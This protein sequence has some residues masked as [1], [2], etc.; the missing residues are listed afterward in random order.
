M[1]INYEKSSSTKA[2]LILDNEEEHPEKINYFVRSENKNRIF[3]KRKCK[4]CENIFYTR[5]N[6]KSVYCS[7][8]CMKED[9]TIEIICP[10][11]E[12]KVRVEKSKHESTKNGINFCSRKCKDFAQTVGSGINV[13][14]QHYGT[15]VR[16]YRKKGKKNL[17]PKCTRCG[18]EED[19][20]MLD[21]HHK[22]KDR[23][24]N[25]L[26]NLEVLCVWCHALE[27]RRDWNVKWG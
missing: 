6:K 26:E 24:N 23:R 8:E 21:V 22:D 27:T 9:R 1:E 12:K 11:C 20:K 25:K 7:Q 4:L 17:L 16:Y 2:F 10:V 14:P 18:Y 13:Q 5:K 19:V 15:G 3:I